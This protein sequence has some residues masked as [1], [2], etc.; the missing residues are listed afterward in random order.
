VQTLIFQLS[1]WH[2]YAKLRLH[3]SETLKR[4]H[5]V[6]EELCKTIRKFAR[7]TAEEKTYELPREQQARARRTAATAAK[8]A[9]SNDAGTTVPVASAR[10]EKPLNLQT[11]KYHALPDYPA[12]IPLIGTTDSTSTQIV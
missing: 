9:S 1:H 5:D 10:R 4:F 3:S 12:S 2:A 6:T 11:Y 7:E 8:K